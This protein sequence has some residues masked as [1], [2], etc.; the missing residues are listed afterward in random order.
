MSMT[1]EEFVSESLKQVVDGVVEAQEH[2][3]NK[4]AMVNPG[5]GR[6]ETG[7]KFVEREEGLVPSQEIEFDVAVTS[8]E[9]SMK[10]AKA[11][12]FV[13]AFG[14]GGEG[15]KEVTNSLVSRIRFSVPVIF[16]VHGP[17]E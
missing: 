4:G 1:L 16:P 14:I 7:Q 8:V 5:Y 11:R 17:F 2:A 13:G 9:G 3:R 6:L 15:G 10:E 12:I